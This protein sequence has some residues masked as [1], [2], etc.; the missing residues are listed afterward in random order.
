MRVLCAAVLVLL[1]P[2]TISA[3]EEAPPKKEA[4]KPEPNSIKEAI[5]A[6]LKEL[7][8]GEIPL[9]WLSCT[10]GAGGTPEDSY[11]LH[12]NNLVWEAVT[13]R[14]LA[15][16]GACKEAKGKP[17]YLYFCVFKTPEPKP[18]EKLPRFIG[19]PAPELLSLS[20]SSSN[21]GQKG[22]LEVKLLGKKVTFAH[23]A[24]YDEKTQKVTVNSVKLNGK[25]LKDERAKVFVVDLT[26]AEATIHPV[27]VELP[28][29]IV[30]L[31][32]SD[33]KE[34]KSKENNTAILKAV[35]EIRKAPE[36]K[37]LLEAEK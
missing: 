5:E 37:K 14:P 21:E 9:G 30:D 22:T 17:R 33:N 27:E 18:G 25:E 16:F 10:T 23:N 8:E 28:K 29:S 15:W 12:P 1:V 2:V 19:L 6:G 20:G 7:K 11:W 36:V 3:E 35:E 24:T 34:A 31:A 13:V 32:E 4:A 26:G